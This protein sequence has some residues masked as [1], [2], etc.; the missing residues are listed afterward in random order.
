MTR[1]FE[2]IA[3]WKRDLPSSI[4]SNRR[5]VACVLV[6]ESLERREMDTEVYCLFHPASE[7][8]KA[9]S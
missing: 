7:D 6:E 1:E 4:E 9:W 3:V 8:K 5:P 2:L